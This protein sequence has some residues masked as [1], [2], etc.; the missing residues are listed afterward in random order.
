MTQANVYYV[1]LHVRLSDGRVFYVGKGKG[2]RHKSKRDRNKWWHHVADKHGYH[3][4][5]IAS[6]LNEWCAYTLEMVEIAKQRSL[7][8]PL[9]NQTDGGEGSRGFI[10]SWRKAVHCSNGMRFDSLTSASEWLISQGHAKAKPSSVSAVCLGKVANCY[11]HTFWLDGDPERELTNAKK[12]AQALNA[13]PVKCSN[14]M[15]FGSMADAAEW[16]VENVSAKYTR[17]KICSSCKG[18]SKTHHGLSWSYA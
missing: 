15:R 7:G 1:Y 16:A 2:R 11:G 12:A 6:G 8:S 10:P 3:T 18:R 17:S 4:V 9:V 14:G 13:K 5:F